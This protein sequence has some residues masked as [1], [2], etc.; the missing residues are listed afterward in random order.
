[1]KTN[2]KILLLLYLLLLLD[3]AKPFG[4]LLVVDFVLIGYIFTCLNSRL[5]ISLIFG[6]VFGYLRN[7]LL[8][9]PNIFNLL[10]FPLICLGLRYLSKELNFSQKRFYFL[11]LENLI[12]LIILLVHALLGSLARGNFCLSFFWQFIWQSFLVYCFIS[13]ILKR[14]SANLKWQS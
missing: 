7:C 1:M 9:N 12:V 2:L 3:L 14:Y 5:F 11:T 6:I 8:F 13:F 10:E 4:Y